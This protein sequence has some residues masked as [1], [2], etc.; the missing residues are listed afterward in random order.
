MPDD[1]G[2]VRRVP[3]QLR[4]RGRVSRTRRV[5]SGV[6]DMDGLGVRLLT[7]DGRVLPL[8]PK[9][10]CNPKARIEREEIE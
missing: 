3:Y 1:E 5:E 6:I 2:F 8:A 9:D 10:Y 7:D 4:F